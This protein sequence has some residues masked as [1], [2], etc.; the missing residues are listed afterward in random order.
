MNDDITIITTSIDS[1]IGYPKKF[2]RFPRIIHRFYS[3]DRYPKIPNYKI[4]LISMKLRYPEDFEKEFI[5]GRKLIKIRT[6]LSKNIQDSI[7]TAAKQ[8]TERYDAKIVIFSEFSYPRSEHETLGTS[9]QKICEDRTCFVVGGSFHEVNTDEDDFAKNKCF[10]FTP[11]SKDPAVQCKNHP[12][13]F[14]GED[15][16]I[17]TD[18]VPKINVFHTSYGAF[19]VQICIDI[20]LK[21][22]LNNISVNN[23]SNNNY[24]P[25]ELIIVPSY[26]NQPNELLES[27]YELANWSKVIVVYVNDRS[28]GD[29]STVFMCQEELEHLDRVEFSDGTLLDIYD[30]DLCKLFEEQ[31]LFFSSVCL[32]PV[33]ME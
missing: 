18:S 11:V 12:G 14:D 17:L 8:A 26:T 9:L 23:K 4:A 19:G 25:I 33:K 7:L 20:T 13:A 3:Y 31:R 16:D 1:A 29:Y 27:C 28:Y 10:I 6:A 5:Q 30:I 15:E 32:T 22:V 2:V 24:P 21:D